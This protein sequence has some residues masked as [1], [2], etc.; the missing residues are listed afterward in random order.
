MGGKI[1]QEDDL[2]R[3]MR[4]AQ[5]GDARAYST[6]LHILAPKVRE[7]V[8]RRLRSLQ[9]QDVDDLVQDILLSVHAARATY[10]PS[11]PFLPWLAAIAR[12]RMAD[13]ARRYGRRAAHEVAPDRPV[14]TFAA[15]DTNMP[16][17]RYGDSEALAQ[18]MTKLPQ[19]QRQALELTKL[20]EMSLKEA[21]AATGSSVGALKVSVHRGI[22]ALRKALGGEN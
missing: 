19:G 4:A 14:E 12:N 3:L 17:N 9:P 13:S 10:D 18:A 8:R 22:S 5:A 7:M 11:R 21:A 15:D 2:P 6:L 20:R 16:A 1:G